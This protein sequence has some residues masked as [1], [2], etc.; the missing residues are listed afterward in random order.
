M[1]TDKETKLATSYLISMPSPPFMGKGHVLFA[2]PSPDCRR[3]WPC[4]KCLT[5]ND[6]CR[7]RCINLLEGGA[8]ASTSPSMISSSSSSYSS[9]FSSYC[10][11]S[12]NHAGASS[13]IVISDS[14]LHLDNALILSKEMASTSDVLSIFLIQ[15]WRL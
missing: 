12:S 14:T 7:N 15:S 13:M 4:M 1:Y 3:P 8:N 11:S 2:R 9:S 5:V 10:R 6:R